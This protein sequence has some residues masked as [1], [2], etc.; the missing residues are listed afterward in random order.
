MFPQLLRHVDLSYHTSIYHSLPSSSFFLVHFRIFVH[1][2]M[3]TKYDIMISYHITAGLNTYIEYSSI[4]DGMIP[5]MQDNTGTGN[6]R[7][8]GLPWVAV[9]W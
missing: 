3:D 8:I 1:Y 6:A 2:N 5:R 7:E 9:V 4:I